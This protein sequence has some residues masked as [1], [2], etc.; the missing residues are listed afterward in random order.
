MIEVPLS[1]DKHF[2]IINNM[3]LWKNDHAYAEGK[4]DTKL[5]Y[6]LKMFETYS[7]GGK[8]LKGPILTQF[9]EIRTV[10]PTT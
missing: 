1:K 6:N 4:R 2:M 9:F 8:K 3:F 10:R 5:I 7:S